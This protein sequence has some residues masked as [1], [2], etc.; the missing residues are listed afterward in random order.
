MK[1]LR[2]LP[3]VTLCLLLSAFSCTGGSKEQSAQSVPDSVTVTA[4]DEPLQHIQPVGVYVMPDI[5]Y[6]QYMS[7]FLDEEID[8]KIPEDCGAFDILYNPGCS[9]YC[10]GIIDTVTATSCHK[11]EGLHTY[12]AMH[13]HDFDHESVWA[14]QGRGIGESLTFQFPGKCPR[15][16][17]VSIL[18]GHVK[19]EKA[20]RSNSRAKQVLMYYN[21]RPYR[22]LELEDSRTLQ[23]FEVDTLGY[24]PKAG[25]TTPW[26]LRFEI[27]EVYPG[28]KYDDLV[29]ADFVFD[30]IDV[31]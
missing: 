24:G 6:D 16:T 1:T 30:G 4:S 31:H 17:A 21:D 10:G 14:S 27:Q 26:T 19:S 28:D 9:W 20:W 11:P 5:T 7:A 18:N 8:V 22:I 12:D 3:L 2:L 13:A 29:I 25:K 15:V 23:R